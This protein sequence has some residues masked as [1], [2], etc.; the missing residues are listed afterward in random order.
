MIMIATFVL[1]RVTH[2]KLC[3]YQKHISPILNGFG[4]AVSAI[5]SVHWENSICDCAIEVNFQVY[6]L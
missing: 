2:E 5:L 3:H 1:G 4:I 6:I